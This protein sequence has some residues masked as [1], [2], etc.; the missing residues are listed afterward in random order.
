MDILSRVW[1]MFGDG[2]IHAL[3]QVLQCG[4]IWPECLRLRCSNRAVPMTSCVFA[5]CS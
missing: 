1:A 3:C 4:V 5:R 2:V